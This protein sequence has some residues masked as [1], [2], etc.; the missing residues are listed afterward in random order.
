MPQAADILSDPEIN[1]AYE[2]VR[3][4]KS[5]TTWLVLKVNIYLLPLPSLHNSRQHKPFLLQSST[6]RTNART[7]CIR[8]VR[9]SQTRRHRHRRHC[10]DD[11]DAGR[12]RSGVCVCAHEAGERRVLGESQVCV[13]GVAGYVFMTNL[14]LELSS[15]ASCNELTIHLSRERGGC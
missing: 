8:L 15:I 6:R 5:E 4:D 7:V 12:R 10:R 11:G 2:D 13:C 1:Q 9:Q 3:S 14:S